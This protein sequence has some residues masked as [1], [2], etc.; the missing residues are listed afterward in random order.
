MSDLPIIG[1]SLSLD[2]FEAYRPW[3]FEKQRDLDLHGLFTPD[4]LNQDLSKHIERANTLL[5]GY[6]GRL[7]IHGPCWGFNLASHDPDVR[8]VIQKRM[9]HALDVCQMIGAT[10]MVIHSPYTFWDYNNIDKREGEREALVERVHLNLSDA[11]TRAEEIGCV[12]VLENI[13]DKDPQDRLAL[14]DSFNSQSVAVSLDTGHAHYACCS[15]GAPPVDYYIKAA[16]NRLHHVHL[17]D[18]DGYADRHWSVGEG[19]VPWMA[20]FRALA[21]LTSRPRLLLEVFGAQDLRRSVEYLANLK[22]AQ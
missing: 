16:G 12:L 19:S 1:A 21:K 7:G 20:V 6:R 9:A 15:F 8:L 18:V 22:L 3:V 11:V 4:V 14:A 17:H 2:E 13:E 10:Q 5:D